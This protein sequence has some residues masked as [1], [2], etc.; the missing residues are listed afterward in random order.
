MQNRFY[1]PELDVLR[2]LAFG[3]VFLRHT[4]A[5]IAGDMQRT[6]GMQAFLAELSA[7]GSYGVDLFF[8]L[9]AYLITELF[10]REIA[11]GGAGG[12]GRVTRST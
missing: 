4:G 3:M 5:S 1:R 7:S 10:M 9:S 12:G 8:L 11:R 2:F 6:G